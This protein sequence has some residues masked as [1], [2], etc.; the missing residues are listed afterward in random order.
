MHDNKRQR[1]R[2]NYDGI[3]LK[4][5]IYSRV[6]RLKFDNEKINPLCPGK[7]AN[8]LTLAT[9]SQWPKTLKHT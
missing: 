3:T 5:S 8:K 9:I 7:T 6:L 4:N 2:L 1:T